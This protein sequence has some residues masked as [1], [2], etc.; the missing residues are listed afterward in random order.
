MSFN[1]ELLRQYIISNFLNEQISIENNSK[2]E[3]ELDS[4]IEMP[5]IEKTITEE[6]TEPK[7][8]PKNDYKYLDNDILSKEFCLDR[9]RE[10]LEM[11]KYTISLC[12]FN[13]N[14][15][16]KTPFLEFLFDNQTGEF[17]FPK[18]ELQMDVLANLYKKEN[19]RKINIENTTP[20][21][22]MNSLT[23]EDY[24]D[25]T[26]IE[27]MCDE[28]EMEFFN[29]CSKFAQEIV[30]LTN[31]V[32]KQRY[33]GFI[34]KDDILYVIF[35]VT[36][37]TILENINN[38]N[39]NGYFIGIID[40]II[41]K[42]KIFETPIDEKIIDLFE[43]SPLLKN[44]YDY[45]NKEIF[46]PKLVYLCVDEDLDTEDNEVQI[47]P[48]NTIVEEKPIIIETNNNYIQEKSDIVHTKS[49]FIEKKI[50]NKP[51]ENNDQVKPDQAQPG[52]IN[53]EQKPLEQVKPGEIKPDQAQ[54]DQGQPDQAQSDQVKPDEIN[55]EQKPLDK[56]QPDEIN[57]EQKPLDKAQPDEINAEQKLLDQAQPDKINAEQKQ[58]ENVQPEPG[59]PVVEEKK[60][61]Q[62]NPSEMPINQLQK[63]PVQ[64]PINQKGGSTY[65]NMY[66]KKDD[67]IKSQSTILSF[68]NPK[69]NH[70]LFDYV[71]LFTSEPFI[72]DSQKGIAQ[73]MLSVVI[74][75]TTTTD[76]INKIKRYALEIDSV[77]YYKDVDVKTLIEKNE[78]ISPNYDVYCFYEDNREYWAVKSKNNFTEI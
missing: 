76:E 72:K 57:A 15:E 23:S 62:L 51:I 48:I 12:F 4:F 22:K 45:N 68:I 73:E 50:E 43:S 32:L 49:P 66:Y 47:E 75:N 7:S 31:D 71:Y 46:V 5:V 35:D 69:V 24:D 63:Q 3:S 19:E 28:V 29:Q 8:E 65:K 53:V 70:P 40:E 13:I 10:I 77:K 26:E 9:E 30:F 41:N 25:E 18:K 56:A 64:N 14:E 20:F 16:L 54:P 36:N 39:K 11:K 38:N 55:A 74:D 2:N 78:I 58:L 37:I 61:E 33:L 27:T 67:T 52:E 60:N 34:E 59:E 44:I 1:N 21:Q 17:S 6:K 42:K